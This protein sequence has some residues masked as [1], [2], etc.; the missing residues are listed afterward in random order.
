MTRLWREFVAQLGFGPVESY[1]RAIRSRY[2]LPPL[3]LVLLFEFASA[4]ITTKA[5][6]ADSVE[7]LLRHPRVNVSPSA[8][9]NIFRPTPGLPFKRGIAAVFWTSLD[10]AFFTIG[11]TMFGMLARQELLPREAMAIVAHAFFLTSVLA[12]L[13]EVPLALYHNSLFYSQVSAATALLDL[14]ELRWHSYVL[15]QM[16]LFLIGRVAS[17]GCGIAILC[18]WPFLIGFSAA[19]FLWAIKVSVVTF[20]LWV[21]FGM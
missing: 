21:F 9:E 11:V 1:R 6:A 15:G 19:F 12:K 4:A 20:Y 5:A 13:I 10:I 3:I 7:A 18:R 14:G 17:M 16:N 2:L 8:A